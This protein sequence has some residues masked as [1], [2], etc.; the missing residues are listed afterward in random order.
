MIKKVLVT[1]AD[2]FIGSHLTEE[3]VKEGYEV[4]AFAMYNSFNTVT[5]CI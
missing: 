3:L 1:G 4:R 2:G 5:K